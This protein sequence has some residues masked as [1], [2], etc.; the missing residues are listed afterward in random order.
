MEKFKKQFVTFEIA[1]KLKELGFNE[2]CIA[3]YFE[4]GEL[5]T[6]GSNFFKIAVFI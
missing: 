4:D 2:G 3:V 1:K 5:H 6:I